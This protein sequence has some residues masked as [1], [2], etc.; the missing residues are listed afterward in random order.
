MYAG[1]SCRHVCGSSKS[2]RPGD[3][4]MTT[5]GMFAPMFGDYY[6]ITTGWTEFRYEMWNALQRI[7]TGDGTVESILA[8][9]ETVEANVAAAL[10]AK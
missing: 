8:E 6:Q 4:I 3:E 10:A 5:Y 7:G 1:I 9:L 2:Y